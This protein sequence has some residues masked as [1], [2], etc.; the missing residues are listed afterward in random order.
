[1]TLATGEVVGFQG[2]RQKN[3]ASS[4]SAPTFDKFSKDATTL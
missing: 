2:V 1:M 4:R 3:G